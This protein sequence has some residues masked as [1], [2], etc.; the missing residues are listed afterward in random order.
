MGLAV[1]FPQGILVGVR[2]TVIIMTECVIR[3]RKRHH[4]T[5]TGGNDLIWERE[6][7]REVESSST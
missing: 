4:H 3:S 2:T 1:L 6:T 5:E 7:Q